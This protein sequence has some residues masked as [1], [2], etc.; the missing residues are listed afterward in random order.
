MRFGASAIDHLPFRCAT[1]DFGHALLGAYDGVESWTIMAGRERSAFEQLLVS[2]HERKHHELQTSTPWGFLMMVA[3][4]AAPDRQVVGHLADGCRQSHELYATYFSV[5]DDS[6]FRAMLAGNPT[7]L[8]YY[9]R[10]RRLAS[11]PTGEASARWADAT[12]RAVMAPRA[13]LDLAA[14]DIV[15]L[16]AADLRQQLLPDVRLRHLERAA[17]SLP[18]DD[19]LDRIALDSEGMSIYRDE[20][21]RILTEAGIDTM[22][23]AEHHAWASRLIDELTAGRGAHAFQFSLATTAPDDQLLSELD[24]HGRERIQLHA[25]KLPLKIVAPVQLPERTQDFAR[26]H[27]GFGPHCLLVWLRRDLLTRQFDTIDT[28]MSTNQDTILGLLACDRADG[29]AV[30][31]LCPFDV[32]PS[33]LYAVFKNHIRLLFL[34]TLATIVDTPESEDFRG[35]S[36]VFALIDQ[37]V[38]EFC[39][40]TMRQGARLSWCVIRVE[41]GLDLAVFLF[42]NAE[43]PEMIYLSFATAATRHYLGRWLTGHEGELCQHSHRL[44]AAHEAAIGA[45]VEHV[46]AIFWRLDQ[47]GGRTSRDA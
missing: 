22:T 8:G 3:G 14:A 18:M 10:A 24:D 45:L 4:R 43:I 31:R 28:T 7:Y 15:E 21:S 36:P 39:L 44:V 34:T 23:H 13:L 40:H 32:S 25:Q 46:V 41:G 6:D 42:E 11:S 17:R 38:T 47:F 20:I 29:E 9:K 5:G 30:A 16:S 19:E 12:L 35:I 26:A 33:M 37:P 27:S 2:L 1:G